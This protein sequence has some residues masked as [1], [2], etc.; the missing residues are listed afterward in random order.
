MSGPTDR[1]QVEFLAYIQRVF[2]EGSFV[3]TYKFALMLALA[4]LSVERGRDDRSELELHVRD[5]ARM[6]LRYY[7]RQCLPF[8]GADGLGELQQNTG[9]QAGVVN[10]VREAHAVYEVQGPLGAD[11]LAA[12]PGLIGRVA[13]TIRTQPLWKL[14]TLGSERVDFLYPNLDRG[15]VI[16]LRPGIAACFRKFHGLVCGLTQDAWIRYIRQRPGNQP[17]LG[18]T[19]DLHAFMFGRERRDLGTYQPILRELQHGA[20]FYCG[21][22]G[23]GQEVDHFVPWSRYRNDLSHNFVLACGPCNR[24]K[25]DFLAAERHLDRW[26]ER[27]ETHGTA[28]ASFF[29]EK[30]LPHDAA[31]SLMIARWAY[32][33]ADAAKALVW[34]GGKQFH[35]LE[36][37]WRQRFPGAHAKA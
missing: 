34:I 30:L 12:V 2:S 18:D 9:G 29:D 24:A 36:T 25:C 14:Q 1:F 6:F 20:C 11:R 4:D 7:D 16:T 8:V 27:N 13:A 31:G 19:M 33:Q 17:L 23:S 3:A 26:L 15:N 10:M 35:H 28:M 32:E 5:L 22:S 37:S 21:R